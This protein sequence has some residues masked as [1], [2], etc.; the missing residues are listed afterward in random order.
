MKRTYI[1][2]VNA[3]LCG[4]FL[5]SLGA[6]NAFLDEEPLSF[7]NPENYLKSEEQLLAYVDKYYADFISSNTHEDDD[8]TDNQKGTNERYMKDTWTVAQKEKDDG[9]GDW[10]FTKIYA[11]NYYLQTVVPRYEEGNISGNDVNIKQ[12]IGEGYFLRA[13]DYFKRLQKLGD[14][15]F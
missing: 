10:D 14:F 12:Y 5:F 1:K 3:L 13:L 7:V 8:A 4:F 11:M 6:C 9:S 2:I 15:P